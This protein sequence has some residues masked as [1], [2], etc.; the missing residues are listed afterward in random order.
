M[1][2]LILFLAGLAGN[3]AAVAVFLVLRNLMRVRCSRCGS[4]ERKGRFCAECGSEFE[5]TCLKCGTDVPAEDHYC[6]SCGALLQ[7]PDGKSENGSK[8][9]S[10]DTEESR[11]SDTDE[12]NSEETNEQES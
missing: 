9:G 10:D 12:N 8:T 6:S 11:D 1:H 7:E 2:S 4:W 3:H 5:V